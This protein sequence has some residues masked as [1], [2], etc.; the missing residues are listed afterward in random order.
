M[1]FYVRYGIPFW[2][3]VQKSRRDT[4][5]DVQWHSSGTFNVLN[6]IV[7]NASDTREI[8]GQVDREDQAIGS[9]VGKYGKNTGYT[10][11]YI[12][13]NNVVLDYIPDCKATFFE[14]EHSETYPKL[15]DSGDSGGPWF[16]GSDAYGTTC[17]KDSG[18]NAYY[19]AINYVSGLG[20]KL[21]TEP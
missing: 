15:C 7:S 1:L 4:Y 6:Q 14:V 20:V 8:T 19:M 3:P 2:L 18:G 5:Y 17:A 11:G 12:S 21:L 16:V 9:F 13:R 10:A